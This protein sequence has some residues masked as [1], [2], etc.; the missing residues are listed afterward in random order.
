MIIK[1]EWWNE[2]GY[3]RGL[4]V[5]IAEWGDGTKGVN[6]LRLYKDD[7]VVEVDQDAGISLTIPQF[8]WLFGAMDE[9]S[10]DL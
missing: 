7:G 8:V 10:D 3:E 5:E 1:E 9:V 6:I 2:H 4:R